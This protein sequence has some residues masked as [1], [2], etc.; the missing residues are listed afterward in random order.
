MELEKYLDD[1]EARLNTDEEARLRDAWLCWADHLN[2][3]KLFE[4]PA[5]T[6]SRSAL[7]WPHVNINDTLGDTGLSVYRELENINRA[8]ERGTSGILRVRPNFGVGNIATAFGAELFIMPRETDE[9]PNVKRLD[10]DGL[11]AILER[12]LPDMTAGNFAMIMRAAERLQRIRERYPKFAACVR[13]EQPD[14]QGPMDNLELL[15]GSEM[16]CAFYDEP[17]TVHAL[18]GRITDMIEKA[19]D[20]WLRLFQDPYRTAGYFRHIE[21]GAI[22]LRNDSAMNLSEAFFREFIMPYDGRLLKKYGGLVH[23]CGRGDH[24]IGALTELEGL[25]GINMSQPHLNDMEKIFSLTVD[26]GIHLSISAKPFK[27]TGHR[28]GELVFLP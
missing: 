4:P 20:A 12:P 28:L 23:F 3:D 16:F 18:L 21:R 17:D 26:R 9:L 10:G 22:A 19:M 8:L 14:L 6:A 7:D 27:V 24:F 25:N 15:W 1:I 2:G 11:R 13:M 5:R